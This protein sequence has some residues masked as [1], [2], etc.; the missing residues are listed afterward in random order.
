MGNEP[1]VILGSER[2]APP[3]FAGRRSE[4]A[5]LR[6]RLD[7]IR[8]SGDPSGGMVQVDGVKGAGKTQLIA[9]FLN[10]ASAVPNVYV[11]SVLT[12]NLRDQ[13]AMFDKIVQAIG[14]SGSYIRHRVASTLSSVTDLSL[15]R[16]ALGFKRQT[17]ESPAAALQD[18][19]HTSSRN[20]ELWQGKT[21]LIAVDEVQNVTSA[22]SVCR[23][24]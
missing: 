12:S 3:H 1:S 5:T 24:M 13:D 17:A 8:Q 9:R 10:E 15:A 21:L 6:R 14:A 7:Y 19:L 11:L 20:K 18:K 16:G 23:W 4:L 2:D 22:T